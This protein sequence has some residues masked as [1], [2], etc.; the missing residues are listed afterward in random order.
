MPDDLQPYWRRRRR[1]TA[2]TMIRTATPL[3]LRFPHGLGVQSL[4]LTPVLV[5]KR[6]DFAGL[7]FAAAAPED[8]GVGDGDALIG[9]VGVD[10]VFVGEE[11]LL[12]G[13]VG[14]AH[15]VDVIEFR[16]ALAPI[17]VGHDVEAPDLPAGVDFPAGR[18]GPVKEGVEAGDALAVGERLDV[19]EEG[20]ESPDDAAAIEVVG[21]A[22]KFLAAETPGLAGAVRTRGRGRFPRA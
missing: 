13:A 19:L 14:D 20:G 1:R 8:V 15:D 4:G 9:E 16:P 10:G 22:A 11:Q 18:D 3:I 5:L 21:D 12:V 7:D 2:A 17:G 6:R